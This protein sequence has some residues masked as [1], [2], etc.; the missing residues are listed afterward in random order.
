LCF[1]FWVGVGGVWL[2]WGEGGGEGGWGG[3]GGGGWGGG[4]G[5]VTDQKPIMAPKKCNR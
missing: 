5:G 3:W 4:G 1:G 2:G